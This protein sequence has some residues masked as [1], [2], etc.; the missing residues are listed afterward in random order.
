[1]R[2]KYSI[3]VS[4]GWDKRLI[5]EILPFDIPHRCPCDS[6][7]VAHG[8]IRVASNHRLCV[9]GGPARTAGVRCSGWPSV[10]GRKKNSETY[11]M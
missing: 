8:V 11:V 7:A 4:N 5:L 10:K 2:P 3:V 9:R 1:M 6:R